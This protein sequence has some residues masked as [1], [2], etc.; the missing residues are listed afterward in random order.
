MRRNNMFDFFKKK[1]KEVNNEKTTNINNRA[2]LSKIDLRKKTVNLICLEKKE[3]INL[4]S[5]VALVLDFSYS[6]E[7][8]YTNGTVQDIVE[9]IFPLALQFDKDGELD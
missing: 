6:M 1:N 9:R 4:K 8:L 3:L 5:K 7:R 2:N